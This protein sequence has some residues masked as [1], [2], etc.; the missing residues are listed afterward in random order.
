MLS[1]NSSVVGRTWLRSTCLPGCCGY[2]SDCDRTMTCGLGRGN[3]ATSCRP[4]PMSR[5]SNGSTPRTY[6][7]CLGPKAE[8]ILIIFLS[9]WLLF[10][11]FFSKKKI[12]AA[13]NVKLHNQNA[14]IFFFFFSIDNC[15]CF[16]MRSNVSLRTTKP[17]QI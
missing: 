3:P 11:Q 5:S 13:S 17:F 14:N 4:Q 7:N 1:Q 16:L 6:L 9:L 10:D 8:A 15:H 2:S 12:K